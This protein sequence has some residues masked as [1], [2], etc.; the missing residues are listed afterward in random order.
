MSALWNLGIRLSGAPTTLVL[1]DDL[2][3]N[4]ELVGSCFQALVEACQT[5]HLAILNDSFGHFAI[6]RECIRQVGWFDERFLGFGEEDGDYAWRFEHVFG[7]PIC[8][9]WRSGI[10]NQSVS[11]RSRETSSSYRS[12]LFNFN[13]TFLHQKYSFG[14]GHEISSRFSAPIARKLS[15]ISPIPIDS[16][17]DQLEIFLWKD[18][19]PDEV[20]TGIEAAI[21]HF[22]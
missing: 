10:T 12:R 9:I 14:P 17:M 19:N 11:R 3:V 4:I 2:A 15:E 16:W 21:K 8:V 5:T 20:R 22:L 7:R 18:A 13:Q 6:S 1:N